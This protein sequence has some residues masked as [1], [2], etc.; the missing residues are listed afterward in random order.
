[1]SQ[2]GAQRRVSPYLRESRALRS[3]EVLGRR[4]GLWTFFVTVRN[5]VLILTH[6]DSCPVLEEQA[7]SLSLRW[8]FCFSAPAPVVLARRPSLWF[9]RGGLASSSSSACWRG[10][11]HTLPIPKRQALFQCF[12]CGARRAWQMKPKTNLA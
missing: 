5:P 11:R 7:V 10:G 1:M 3:R 12:W 8:F 6:T 4:Q 9:A 2:A